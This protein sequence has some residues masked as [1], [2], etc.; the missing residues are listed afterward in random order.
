MSTVINCFFFNLNCI[1]IFVFYFSRCGN[2]SR[3]NPTISQ[4][5]HRIHLLNCVDY[6][7]NYLK[8]SSKEEYDMVI[9]AQNIRNGMREIGKI[10]G[11]VNTEE[12]L[13]VI[14]TNFC[15]GK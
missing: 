13:D 4:A 1:Y 10:T 15:I 6:L 2:P 7:L 9:A 12:I 3:E 14:F 8:M 5:R 11:H